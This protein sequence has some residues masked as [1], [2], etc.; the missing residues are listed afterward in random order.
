MAEK[1]KDAAAP[2]SVT[3]EIR[4]P[5][6]EVWGTL[7]ASAKDFKTGSVGFYGS[8]KIQNP[9]SGAKYQVGANIILVG[10]KG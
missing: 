10:S 1:T 6:G 2:A 8:G 5:E 3:L 7:V 4:G 9:R